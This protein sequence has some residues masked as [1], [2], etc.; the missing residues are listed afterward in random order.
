MRAVKAYVTI[1]SRAG[2]GERRAT[3]ELRKGLNSGFFGGGSGEELAMHASVTA[4][5][6]MREVR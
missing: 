4:L 6:L 3:L 5:E 2:L 1:D